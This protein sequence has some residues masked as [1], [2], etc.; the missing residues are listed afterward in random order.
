MS[1]RDPHLLRTGVH[2]KLGRRALGQLRAAI[3]VAGRIV[4]VHRDTDAWLVSGNLT[5]YPPGH[6]PQPAQ[7]AVQ[8]LGGRTGPAERRPLSLAAKASAAARLHRRHASSRITA[9]WAS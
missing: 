4:P 3:C 7:L 1:G 6:G 8:T 2:S 9:R 5:T